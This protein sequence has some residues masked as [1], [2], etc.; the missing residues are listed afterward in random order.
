MT[1]RN[2]FTQIVKTHWTG[3]NTLAI[4]PISIRRSSVVEQLTVNQFVVGSTPT[5]GANSLNK[6]SDLA[7]T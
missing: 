3:Q 5:A 7:D 2:F 4:W 6:N 1:G